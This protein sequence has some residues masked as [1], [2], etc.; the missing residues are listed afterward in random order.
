M[1]VVGRQDRQA[2]LK[3]SRS[4]QNIRQTGAAPMSNRRV[5]HFSC[6][7]GDGGTYGQDSLIEFGQQAIK[8]AFKTFRSLDAA[9]A[10]RLGDVFLDFSRRYNRNVPSL[11]ST[12]T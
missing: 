4:Y 11:V 8:P 5:F 9:G 12:R 10:P 7:S 2:V 1:T 6:S 3:S